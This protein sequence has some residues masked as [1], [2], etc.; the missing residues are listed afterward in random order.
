MDNE[1]A[2]LILSA[3]RPTDED[4][5]DPFFSEALE[6]SRIDPN[7]AGWFAA[8]RRFDMLMT[9]AIRAQ[10]PPEHLRR[11]LLLGNKIVSLHQHTKRPFWS[12]P[13]SWFALA[14][15]VAIFLGLGVL[16]Q[17]VTKPLMTG[18][19]F[20][21]EVIGLAESGRI[22]LGKMANN[23]QDLK[24]WLAS[25]GSP[26]DFPIPDGLK[27]Y[28]GMGCQTFVVNGARVSLMC[29]M[30][31]KDQVVHLFVID[32]ASLKDAP[33]STPSIVREHDQVAATWSSGGKTYL[34]L[35][36]NVSAE[37]LRRLI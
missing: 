31:G 3:Y 26:H 14:A 6:Q 35:G 22:T 8:E 29:F 37:T 17:P 4:A 10:E 9:K 24:A 33:G 1:Q 19:Q 21:R 32:G 13:V 15:A 36:I 34:L 23:T 12:R 16:L 25:Q 28:P 27:S 5:S 18:P 7:L 20:A 30:V 11:T 2:K